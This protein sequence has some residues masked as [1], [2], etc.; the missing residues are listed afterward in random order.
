[1]AKLIDIPV[2]TLLIGLT[3]GD[4]Q[5]HFRPNYSRYKLPQNVTRNELRNRVLP[6]S[7]FKF[8]LLGVSRIVW[9]HMP[10]IVETNPIGL[11]TECL[12]SLN[13]TLIA[14]ET[15]RKWAFESKYSHNL[16]MI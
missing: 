4:L 3:V 2:F 12:D 15:G 8:V 11:T 7:I 6:E 5:T 9:D 16:A 10:T 14:L 1:M 13:E